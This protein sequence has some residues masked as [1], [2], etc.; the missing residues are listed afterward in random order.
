[1][2]G[3]SQESIPSSPSAVAETGTGGCK[4]WSC[5]SIGVATATSVWCLLKK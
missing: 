2:V 3:K 4:T 5:V 1:M